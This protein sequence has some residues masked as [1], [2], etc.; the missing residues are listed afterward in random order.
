L[1]DEISVPV[2]YGGDYRLAREILY[3]VADEVVGDYT[4]RASAEWL[5]MVKRYMVE[6]ASTEL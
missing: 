3:R 6:D 1:W 4:A 2:K 5:R